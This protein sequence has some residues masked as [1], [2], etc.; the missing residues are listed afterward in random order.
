MSGYQRRGPGYKIGNWFS[1]AIALICVFG[2]PIVANRP[3]R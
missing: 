1:K 2:I 3:P